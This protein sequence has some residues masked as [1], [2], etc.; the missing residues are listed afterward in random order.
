MANRMRG[1]GLAVLIVAAL[2]RPVSAINLA[3]ASLADPVSEGPTGYASTA[4]GWNLYSPTVATFSNLATISASSSTQAPA[5]FSA[6]IM[7]SAAT[8]DAFI[9]FGSGPYPDAASIASGSPQAWYNSQPVAALFGGTPTAQQQAAFTNAVLQLTQQ[10]FNMSGIAVNLT[11]DPTVAANHTLSVV[12]NSSSIPY[13]GSIGTTNIGQSGFTFIDQDAKYATSVGQL[14]L[15]VAHNLGHEL[16]LSF[17]VPE[18]Y[19]QTG[20]FIDARNATFAMM[21]NPNATFSPAAAAALNQAL[22]SGTPT[23]GL[24]LAQYLDAQP[25]P[26]PTSI[27]AWAAGLVGLAAAARRRAGRVAVAA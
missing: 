19:D 20:N 6:P 17:G 5:S 26:E 18:A 12:S 21:T 9:N 22:R 1:I 16:M 14:E 7:A 25:V 8:A 24:S 11:T 3:P 2:G 23:A 27:L 10:S 15:I 13:P 4:S